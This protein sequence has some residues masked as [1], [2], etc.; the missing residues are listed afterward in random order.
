MNAMSVF[1][2]RPPAACARTLRA[3]AWLLRYPDATLRTALPELR[4][5]LHAEAAL[6]A[7]RLA[8]LDALSACLAAAPELDA[9]ADYVALFDRGQRTSLHLFEHVHGQARERGPAMLDLIATYRAAGLEPLAQGELPDYLPMVLEFASTQPPATARAFLA[10]FAHI[11]QAIEQA[12]SARG[13]GYAAVLAAL[14]DLAGLQP[15]QTAVSGRGRDDDLALDEAW[16]EPPAFGPGS[17]SGA[18]AAAGQPV[19]WHARRFA[20]TTPNDA[21]TP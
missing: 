6:S 10:E 7:E 5:A 18:A 9:E 20:G 1:A 19:H 3:L 8:D 17:C 12:L 2:A 16:S 13:S 21:R 14:L 11:L 4:A 15:L